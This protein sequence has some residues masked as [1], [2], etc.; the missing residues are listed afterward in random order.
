MDSNLH[1]RHWNPPGCRKSDPEAIDLLSSLSRNG[2]RL[3]SPKHIPTFYSTKGRGYTIDLIWANFLGSQL[4]DDCSVTNEN[5]G[6]DHQGL[7]IH[8]MSKKPDPSYRWS[9][10]AWNKIDPRGSR[11]TLAESLQTRLELTANPDDKIAILTEAVKSAQESLGR[12]VRVDRAKSKP[13][14]CE[15]TL[16]PVLKIRN[17]ARKWMILAKSPEAIDCY[18]Q[19]NNHFLT[20]VD[21]LKRR[22]WEKLLE[23]SCD[24]D[25]F[26]I[27]RFSKRTSGGGVLPLKDREGRFMLD[28]E[29]QAKLLFEGTSMTNAP[30]DLSDVHL[31]FDCRFFSY[32][33]ISDA[34][35]GSAISR[36]RPRKAAGIDGIANEML[37]SL[38]PSLSPHLSSLYNNLLTRSI[39]PRSWK[40][41]VTTIIR[42]HGKTD[43]TSPSAYR[44]IALLSTM[45]KL[46]ELILARRLTAWAEQCR[47]LADGHFGGRKGSGTE[48]AV[49]TLEHWIKAKW[50]EGKVVAGLFLD[51]KSAYPSV[52]PKRLIHYLFQQKCPTYLTLLIA[53]FLRNRSTTIKLDDFISLPHRLEIGLPQGSPLSVILYILYNNTLLNKDLSTAQDRISIGYVDDVVHLVAAHSRA[54]AKESLN[55][56][57]TR[58]LQWGKSHGAIFDQAKAQFMWF[59]RDKPPADYFLFGSSS[60][61]A[62]AEVKW[63]GVFLETHAGGPRKRLGLS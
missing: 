39:F 35:V 54:E 49:Y 5:Y 52:H 51:V 60:L 41:A 28:K 63:L 56:E 50:R 7:I 12:R 61:K 21:S 47:I 34:E 9:L 48:D 13:W 22:N 2:F 16:N 59:T 26:R 4:L 36:L 10:P 42:K 14:W 45:G 62:A 29:S 3:S 1:H 37:K 44:P 20:L 38:S 58:S 6:S 31:D 17:R 32:P 8:L 11:P 57:G 15:A 19:W 25:M 46:F 53:D 33:K 23:D 24:E 18:R 27:L 30:I 43:Y 55:Q 40:C